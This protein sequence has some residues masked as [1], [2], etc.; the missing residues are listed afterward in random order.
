[1]VLYN[2]IIFISL[3]ISVI[4]Y[5]HNLSTK[6]TLERESKN[7]QAA[8]ELQKD[9]EIK[10]LYLR[11]FIND[12]TRSYT[13]SFGK[14]EFLFENT[15]F[16]NEIAKS[17]NKIGHFIAVG[18]PLEDNPIGADKISIPDENWK[19]KILEVMARCS[20]IIFRPSFTSSLVWEFEQIIQ[21]DYLS[22]TI[23]CTQKIEDSD[24]DYF[25]KMSKNLVSIK[26]PRLNMLKSYLCFDTNN[27]PHFY[28]ELADIPLY[29][30]LK[31][32]SQKNGTFQDPEAVP[33]PI[34]QL[35]SE[36]AVKYLFICLAIALV[37]TIVYLN[38][39]RIRAK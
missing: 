7:N 15:N 30:S 9:N 31:Y 13:R 32:K 25:R 21:N 2:W 27:K 11:Y 29:R 5:L 22:K 39:I 4:A 35:L 17:V 10:I 20:M 1:M 16:E 18:P 37:A 33:D 34:I 38:V 3:C 28:F 14:W 12:V 23:I 6:G 8:L 36:K 19:E 24:Y 26:L